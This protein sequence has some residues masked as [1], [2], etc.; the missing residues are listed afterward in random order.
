MFK[1]TQSPRF[2]A[3]VKAEV[4]AEDGR[5]VEVKFRVQ[6]HRLPLPR[7]R[8]ITDRIAETRGFDDELLLEVVADWDEVVDD[9]GEKL[10]FSESGL[11]TAFEFGFGPAILAAFWSGMPKAR[12]KN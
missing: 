7:L 3:P 5:R 2:W 10:P 1:L 8:E 11:R 4:Q 12:A 6:F 9:D